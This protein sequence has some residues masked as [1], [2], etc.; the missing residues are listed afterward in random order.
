MSEES[1]WGERSPGI[2]NWVSA[3]Q[4]GLIPP[5]PKKGTALVPNPG[6]LPLM[7][8]VWTVNSNSSSLTF[9]GLISSFVS[10]HSLSLD[11]LVQFTHLRL[12]LI[13][14]AALPFEMILPLLALNPSALISWSDSPR[15]ALVLLI[16]S[17]GGNA[18]LQ[19]MGTDN[20]LS[21]DLEAKVFWAK[22]S[23]T[24]CV[25][26]VRKY[27]QKVPKAICLSAPC[28][29]LWPWEFQGQCFHLND[30]NGF[31]LYFC[32]YQMC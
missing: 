17:F 9:P 19:L 31:Y 28:L 8:L 1:E 5:S 12:R 7:M 27:F 2:W 14:E 32:T 22:E 24:G 13:V 23:M 11:V 3:V 25:S 20:N 15:A 30:M 6:I 16:P 29:H 10:W 18:S 26:Q 4:N 21:K